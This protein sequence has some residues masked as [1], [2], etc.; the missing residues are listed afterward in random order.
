[1]PLT[2]LVIFVFEKDL[3]VELFQRLGIYI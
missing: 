2:L 3:I 1:M